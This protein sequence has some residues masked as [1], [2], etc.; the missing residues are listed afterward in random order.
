MAY[1]QPKA[2]P[3]DLDKRRYFFL[4]MNSYAAI[5]DELGRE[6]AWVEVL[7]TLLSQPE[8]KT[9]PI[10][11]FRLILWA[12]LIDDDPELTLQQ[13]GAL[14]DF[15]AFVRVSLQINQALS[16]QLPDAPA[17]SPEGDDP[18]APAGPSGNGATPSATH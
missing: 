10:K 17:T 4:S 9:V 12:G 15:A 1:R 11:T 2:I 8:T 14:L 6:G 3:V 18:N 7:E 13:V 16:G 5:D